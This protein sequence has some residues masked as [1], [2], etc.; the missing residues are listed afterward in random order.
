MV[1]HFAKLILFKD[2]FFDLVFV[3]IKLFIRES[4]PIF[5]SL[6]FRAFFS[7]V[8]LAHLGIKFREYNDWRSIVGLFAHWMPMYYNWFIFEAF[9]NRFSMHQIKWAFLLYFG[10]FVG[11]IGVAVNVEG[12]PLDSFTQ[13]DVPYGDSCYD[14]AIFISVGRICVTIAWLLAALGVT[15]GKE[16]SIWRTIAATVPGIFYFVAIFL[17]NDYLSMPVLWFL[18]I[19]L[20]VVLHLVPST[21][22]WPWPYIPRHTHYAEERHAMLYIVALGECVIAAGIPARVGLI[23]NGVSHSVADRYAAMLG[24]I[25]LAFF[26]C[27]QNFIASDTAKLEHNGGTHALHVSRFARCLWLTVQ[28]VSVTAMVIAGAICK[29]ITKK[30][31]LSMFFQYWFGASIATIVIGTAVSQL[32]HIYPVGDTRTFSRP[33]RFV[34]R[35]LCGLLVLGFSFIPESVLGE[36]GWILLIGCTVALFTIIEWIGRNKTGARLG[37]HSVDDHENGHNDNHDA[38]SVPLLDHHGKKGEN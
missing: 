10:A 9:L 4:F 1:F 25:I 5:H 29:N 2:E 16:Y 32:M 11:V 27:I 36:P 18:G 35:T 23:I 17:M 26:L 20:D 22:V 15:I 38:H 33:V 37:H 21:I 30:L 14:F 12:C 6:S 8:T 3:V 19:G 13:G 31:E 7:Q 28:F 24:V 34:I